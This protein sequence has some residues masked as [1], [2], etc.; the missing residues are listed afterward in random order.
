MGSDLLVFAGGESTDAAVIAFLAIASTVFV[1][2]NLLRHMW[3]LAF[4]AVASVLHLALIVAFPGID[5]KADEFR[6]FVS[7]D[8][9][10]FVCS[11]FAL[12]KL[13]SHRT[14]TRAK[15]P[16]GKTERIRVPPGTSLT[17]LSYH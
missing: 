4:L 10:V 13:V 6:L 2:C 9:L 15:R 5:L 3:F 17:T 1:H 16:F 11:A 7:A 8:V 14:L 12:E